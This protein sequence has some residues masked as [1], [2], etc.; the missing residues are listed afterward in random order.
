MVEPIPFFI[1]CLILCE[2]TSKWAWHN[3]WNKKSRGL[4]S[5]YYTKGIGKFCSYNTETLKR[6]VYDKLIW[7]KPFNVRLILQT[8]TVLWIK[9]FCCYLE[10]MVKTREL[11]IIKRA[12]IVGAHANYPVTNPIFWLNLPL[13][14]L[15]PVYQ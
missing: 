4:Y 1:S 12:K 14:P 2:G 13:I 6:I 15:S 8:R 10:I 7:I 9:N 3:L 11:S 5:K